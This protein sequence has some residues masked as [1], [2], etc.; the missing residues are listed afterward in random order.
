VRI[1][2]FRWLRLGLR[3]NGPRNVSRKDDQHELESTGEDSRA[4]RWRRDVPRHTLQWCRMGLRA[5]ACRAAPLTRSG[6]A[7]LFRLV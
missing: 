5:P 3:Q 7:L 1:N 2:P 6:A 4:G